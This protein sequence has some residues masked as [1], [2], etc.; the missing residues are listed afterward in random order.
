MAIGGESD[1]GD[2]AGDGDGIDCGGCGRE[3]MK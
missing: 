2:G 1:D 3:K